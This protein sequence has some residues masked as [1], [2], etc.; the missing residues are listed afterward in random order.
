MITYTL[1]LFIAL[2]GGFGAL[3]LYVDKGLKETS[4]NIPVFLPSLFLT[5]ASML[6]IFLLLYW[7]VSLIVS[8]LDR[9]FYWW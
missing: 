9:W 4:R 6:L 3:F 8:L 1:I 7:L 2:F 5:I